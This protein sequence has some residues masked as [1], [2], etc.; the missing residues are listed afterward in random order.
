MPEF[1]YVG[2]H[3]A[4]D[5]EFHPEPVARGSK[6]T[7]TAELA[8]ALRDQPGNWRETKAPRKPRKAAAKKA[9]PK[10]TEES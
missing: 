5:V 1:T 7:V 8:K 6:V 2:P 9:T 3:D 4:V 10:N